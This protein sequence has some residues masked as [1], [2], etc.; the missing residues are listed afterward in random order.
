[1]SNPYDVAYLKGVE[2][3]SAIVTQTLPELAAHVRVLYG[4]I[5]LL[6]VAVIALTV[7]YVKG[8]SE[9][10]LSNG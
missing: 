6:S 2:D 7:A 10:K 3:G 1:M 4:I 8:Y 5:F 9:W